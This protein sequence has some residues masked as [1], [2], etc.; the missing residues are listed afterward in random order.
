MRHPTIGSVTAIGRFMPEK[1]KILIVEDDTPV[2]MMMTYLL[3]QAGCDVQVAS[4]GECLHS[5]GRSV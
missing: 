2:A 1:M 3:T 5:V 4:T